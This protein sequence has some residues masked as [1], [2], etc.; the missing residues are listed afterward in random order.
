MFGGKK[1]K[2][3]AEGVQARA[4]ILNVQDTGMTINDN[5][6]RQ[7]DAAGPAGGRR[8]VR[9]FQEADRL[10]SRDPALRVD[11]YLVR[12]DPS[13]P[14]NVE[15]DAAAVQQAN[16]AVEAQVAE[17]AAAQVPSATSPRTGSSAEARAST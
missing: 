10:A 14:S 5:P 16:A 13:D 12:Y 11:E 17:A 1:K 3:L 2:I 7:V 6:R 4:V 8:A 15:F 9:G